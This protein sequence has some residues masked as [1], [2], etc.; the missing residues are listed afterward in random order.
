MFLIRFFRYSF[1]PKTLIPHAH[2]KLWKAIIYFI[3][4]SIITLFPLNF[5]I[6]QENGWSLDFI[7]ANI[8]EHTPDWVLPDDMKIYAYQLVVP[9][10]EMTYT[11]ENEGL[12]YIFNA[13]GNEEIT[14]KTVSF[15]VDRIV[16]LDGE[17]HQMIAYGYKGFYDEVN[18][19][20]L[21][22]ATG[23]DRIDLYNEFGSMLEA[24]FGSYVI[25]YSLL[26]NTIVNMSIGI[27]F[28]FMLSLVMQL[29]R[30]GYT[31][32]FS[33]KDSLVFIILS[34]GIPAVLSFFVGFVV[35]S[36]AP[37]IYQFGVGVVVM[38]VMLKY[39]KQ[40]FS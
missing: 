30:F 37:V 1:N 40:Y 27:A 19:R 2:Q 9:D 14:G 26:M 38:A 3:I 39:G 17:G 21:N 8:N 18:F 6:V 15:Y 28:I 7:E 4:I 13:T 5:L 36:F 16:Y 32:F 12:T 34:M 35:P 11:F 24:S 33:Y 20:A 10:P 25:L 29:F 31:K 22:L 23:T